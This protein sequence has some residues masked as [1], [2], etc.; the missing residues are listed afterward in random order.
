[1]YFVLP[2][3]YEEHNIGIICLIIYLILYDGMDEYLY[4]KHLT[5][6]GCIIHLREIV[7]EQHKRGIYCSACPDHIP[8]F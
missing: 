8:I 5:S 4:V 2:I 6:Q 7:Y 1:M 3:I